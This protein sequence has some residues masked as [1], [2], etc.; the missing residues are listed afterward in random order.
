MI[1][2]QRQV[3]SRWKLGKRPGCIQAKDLGLFIKKR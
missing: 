1:T 2:G 3:F